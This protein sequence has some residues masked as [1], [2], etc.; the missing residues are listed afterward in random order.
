MTTPGSVPAMLALGNR[1]HRSSGS[2][3]GRYEPCKEPVVSRYFDVI[4]ASTRVSPLRR[5]F[6][7]NNSEGL[8]TWALKRGVAPPTKAEPLGRLSVPILIGE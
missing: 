4:P 3:L 6:L 1:G 8:S 5:G 2:G 7:N